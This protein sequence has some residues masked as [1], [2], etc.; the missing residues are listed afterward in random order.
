MSDELLNKEKY[1][2]LV[3]F[4]RSDRSY[5]FLTE[6]SSLKIGDAVICETLRGIELGKISSSL[7]K[8]EDENSQ[9]SFILRKAIELD[10]ERYEENIKDAEEA[11]KISLKEVHKLNLPMRVTGAEYTLDRTKLQFDFSADERVDFRELARRLASIFHTRIELRQIGPRDRARMI[12][13]LGVCGL[14]LCCSL[15]LNEFDGISINRAKN[16]MLA[17]NIPKLSGQC[18]KLICC[19]KYE[20]DQYSEMKKLF[21]RVGEKIK[22]EDSLFSVTGINILSYSVKLESEDGVKVLSLDEFKALKNKVK[23][24]EAR[25]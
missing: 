13:G 25:S 11:Y 8:D 18:G 19:L 4:D 15:F 10:I 5:Y 21:P 16:Q 12:G 6:D 3:H 7:V 17:L 22:I 20:D 24:D 9:L 14:R 2:V 23:N 1:H